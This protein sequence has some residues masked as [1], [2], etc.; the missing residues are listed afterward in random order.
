MNWEL[1][2]KRSE[3]IMQI[4]SF[5]INKGYLEV[6]TP[7]LSPDLIPE[8]SIEI[9]KTEMINP[10][11]GNKDLYLIPS[12]EI[13]MK[14]L[15]SMGSGDIFQIC[16]SFRNSEQSGRQHNSEF[17]MLEWY[18]TGFGYLDNIQETEELFHFLTDEN[19]P[20]NIKP[21]FARMSM[22]EAFIRYAGFSLEAHYEREQLYSQCLKLDLGPE[23]D[24]SWEVLFNR[25]FID[26]VEPNL[27][28]EKPL[29]LYNYPSRIK[30]L[31]K[32]IDGTL[33]SERWELYAGGMELANCFSEENDRKKIRDYYAE[34]KALKD[35]L[36][37]VSHKVD[38]NFHEFF[39]KGFPRCS[40]VAMGVDRLIMLLTGERSIGGVILFPHL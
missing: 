17:T 16:K 28:Q 23:E 21:P 26:R 14:K 37:P 32:E 4:R 40:G 5:F 38:E 8:S 29:V 7:L 15:L 27:P 1:I 13:W 24:E 33:W 22:E 25:I 3:I 12:P 39:G 19:S 18:K 31:A 20:G 2:K 30:T 11:K 35:A 6:D 36:S 10:F 9:Y 34:E